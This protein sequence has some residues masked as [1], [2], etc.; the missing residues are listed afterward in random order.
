[1]RITV[2]GGSSPRA[3]EPA[4]QE[5]LQLGSILGQA[6]HTV[7]TGGYIGTMEAVSRWRS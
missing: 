4:Y 7:L 3:G 5:A 6:R 2:F 1:M